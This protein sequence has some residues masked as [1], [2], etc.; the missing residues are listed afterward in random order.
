MN[1]FNDWDYDK[2]TLDQKSLTRYSR[3]RVYWKCNICNCSY[4]ASLLSKNKYKCKCQFCKGEKVKEGVSLL[5]TYPKIALEWDYNKNARYIDTVSYG[6]GYMA[7]WNCGKCK[8]SYKQTVG[9]RATAGHNCPFCAG[10]QVNETNSLGSK[11]PLALIIW[12]FKRNK[13]TPFEVTVGS[14][15]ICWWICSKCKS[16]FDRSISPVVHSLIN[17]NVGCPYCSGKKVNSTNS[18]LT[19]KP[20]LAKEW[21]NKNKISSNEIAP[22][23][24]K[25]VW[26]VCSKGHEWKMSPNGR[27]GTG[28]PFCS[29][30]RVC[31]DN[32]L[33]TCVPKLLKE[34]DY[35]KNKVSPNDISYCSAFKAWW[36]CKNG[37]EWKA[38]V[39][40]RNRGIKSTGC[41]HC[42][43]II[44]KPESKWLDSLNI[45]KEYRQFSLKLFNKN[46]RAD[47]YC[48]ATNTVY[49]FYGDYWHGNP[50]KYKSKD[51]NEMC[52]KTFGILFDKT[53][54]REKLIKAAGYKLIT[55][56]ES[57]WKNGNK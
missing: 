26:W 42:S 30:K 32:C 57:D 14:Q 51:L 24:M 17:D 34:W 15:I 28:C 50:K 25:K 18:L 49:E 7:W 31:H 6:S 1:E 40:D 52:K 2:N 3:T 23:S 38:T 47:G 36:V 54:K 4:K 45:K 11:Y 9:K 16:S 39:S 56:W 21:S 29:L 37:H 5:K 43:K 55:I 44:S 10:M 12:D 33:A 22:N 13:K 19:N 41:P 27:R 8:S 35:N 53:I 48:P 46:I 20:D